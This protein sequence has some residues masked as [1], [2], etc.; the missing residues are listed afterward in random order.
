VL[1][2]VGSPP[3]NL[4]SWDCCNQGDTNQGDSIN[5]NV[6]DI[7]KG[8]VTGTDCDSTNTCQN[9]VATSIDQTTNQSV[10]LAGGS[11]VG[12][13]NI[14]S[15]AVLETY[16]V[17][18]CD[19]LPP[20][21]EEAFFDNS[22][23]GPNGEVQTLQ[24]QLTTLTGGDGN[25]GNLPACGYGGTTDNV[26]TYTLIFGTNPTDDG[27][28]PL[29][30]AAASGDASGMVDATVGDDSGGASGSS[31]SDGS[32]QSGDGGGSS[33][34]S[35]S[36]GLSDDGGL[37]GSGGPGSSGSGGGG[38]S[39]GSGSGSSGSGSGS[40][41]SGS[42]SSS[43]GN[44]AASPPDAP[45]VSGNSPGCGCAVVGR[46][47]PSRP[48]AWATVFLAFG[49]LSRSRRSRREEARLQKR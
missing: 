7:V 9:W 5:V 2:F 18:S 45:S 25:N 26:S 14:V 21:G 8:V 40:S 48:A 27:G 3:W 31:E 36:G 16:G 46:E 22:L 44:G 6:G 33:G 30:D 19:M 10:S 11:D 24:Y 42:G 13:A 28:I 17:T 29:L 39:G 43:G 20:N 15:A 37:S 4:S 12:A 41:G 47:G 23:L 34:S 32:S 38:G 1:A 35:G 49:I